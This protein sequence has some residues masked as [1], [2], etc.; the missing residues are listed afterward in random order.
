MVQFHLFVKPR[1]VNRPDSQDES[2]QAGKPARLA[3]FPAVCFAAVLTATPVHADISQTPMFLA[4]QPKPNIMFTLDDS[5]SMSWNCLPDSLC[6]VVNNN[7]QSFVFESDADNVNNARWRSLAY[8]GLAYDPS[9]RYRPWQQ[10]DTTYYPESIAMAAKVDPRLTTVINLADVA[11]DKPY[12]AYYY[13]YKGAT[14]ASANPNPGLGEFTRVKIVSGMVNPPKGAARTDCNKNSP[15]CTGA[16]ELKNFANWYTYYRKR[17]FTAIA[18]VSQAF[19]SLDGNQRIGYGQINKQTAIKVDGADQTTVMLGVRDFLGN[20]AGTGRFD[21]YNQLLAANADG[22]IGTPLRKALDDVGQ[23]FSRSG[24]SGPWAESPGASLGKEYACR[25]TFHILMTDGY[26]NANAASTAGTSNADSTD[27]PV[28]TDPKTNRSYQYVAAKAGSYYNSPANN[29]LADVAMYYWNRDLRPDLENNVPVSDGDLGF[30]QHVVQYTVGLGVNGTLAYPDDTEALKAN[31][32][33]WPDP[34]T[35]QNPQAVDD[36]WHAAVNGHGMYFNAKN[37]TAFR[38]G[39]TSALEHI[40]AQS[41]AASTV[42]FTAESVGVVGAL[43]YAPS[44]E[45]GTWQGHLIARK[46]T[47]SGGIDP[48][49]IWDAATKLPAW[50]SRKIFTWNPIAK[51]AVAFDWGNLTG[52]QK[53]ALVLPEIL[54]Y[55]KGNGALERSQVNGIYRNRLTKLGDIVDSSPA[56]VMQANGSYQRLPGIGDSYR[57]FM[58]GKANRT[59]MLYVGANDGMLHAFNATSGVEIFAYVP[60]AVYSNLKSLS[61]PAY[62][63]RYFVDGKLAEGDAYLSSASAWKTLLLGSTGAGARGVFALDVTTPTTNGAPALGAGNVLW[64]NSADADNDMGYV[65]GKMAVVRLRNGVWAAIYGNGYDSQSK[66]SVLY[67]VDAFTGALIKKFDTG[68]GGASTPN[69]LSTPALLYNTER[70]LIAAYAGDLQGNLWKFDLS[71][72]DAANWK[73]AYK[74]SPMF[75]AKSGGNVQ[76]IVQRPALA[77]HPN[78]G[79]MVMF[80]TGKYFES[81][82]PGNTQVQTAYGIWDRPDVLAK[83]IVDSRDVALQEQKLTA[84]S[85]G[86][87][88]L[89]SITVDFKTKSGWFVDLGLSVGERSIGDPFVTDDSTFWLTTLIPV[90]DPC[91]SGGESRLM[92]INYLSGGEKAVSPFVSGP[93]VIKIAGTMTDIGILINPKVAGPNDPPTPWGQGRT[94]IYLPSDL[95]GGGGPG[96][97]SL[98][99]AK[100]ETLPPLRSWHQLQVGY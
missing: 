83:P 79:Y 15:A 12:Y 58:R 9:I 84:L 69:G 65:L 97:V 13:V 14:P 42:A 76:A 20:S 29:T 24:V 11:Q 3:A 100:A 81:S 49:N 96:A 25:R 23:Y 99:Q 85:G 71:D 82:D 30:W 88:K 2:G 18:G 78:G 51:A 54:D 92:G 98:P 90:N 64:E 43:A 75:V 32:K 22:R 34:G 73:L 37:P 60:N 26:W 27:G 44:F 17:I 6:P 55:L 31:T 50:N 62:S 28:I 5:G 89:T 19:N 72:T 70:E 68:S 36:L 48:V 52:N 63:H 61:D 21:F 8:N 1:L 41:G 59:P 77:F 7:I 67:L 33:S 46:I 10:A 56:Y 74:G 86:N 39:L 4:Q 80:G 40:K 94:R 53:N 66:K 57:T 91:A 35:G 47:A 45:S 87:G 95:G 38:E 93:S 16:E